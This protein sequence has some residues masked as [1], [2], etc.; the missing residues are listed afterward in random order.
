MPKVLGLPEVKV[1]RSKFPRPFK[2]HTTFNNGEIIPIMYDCNITPGDVVEMPLSAII[3]T[4]TPLYPV[5]DN[6]Y[7]DV[8]VWFVPDR[9]TWKHFK[10][11][12]GEN[13]ETFWEEETQYEIPQIEAPENGW[14]IGSLADY[15]GIPTNVGGISVS[16]M[17]FR[18]YCMIW[19]E[20]W[21]D[22]NL[23]EPIFFNDDETTLTGINYN[24]STFDYTTDIQLGA[25]PM[26]AAR[27]ADYYSKALP[28]PQ[29][30]EDVNIPLGTT[31]PVIGTG[32]QLGLQGR[33]NG[34]GTLYSAIGLVSTGNNDPNRL[35][36]TFN[37]KGANDL[38]PNDSTN[39]PVTYANVT[40]G[41][42]VTQVKEDSGLI[43]DLSEALSAT[44]NQ[45][46]T[47][48]ALQR[49]YEALARSGSRYI[50]VLAGIFGVESSDKTLQRPQ[51][52][53]GK[54]VPMN[55][56]QIVATAE[57]NNNDLGETGAMSQ[58][59]INDYLGTFSFE[60]HGTLMVLAVARHEHTYSQG[61]PRMLLRK[62]QFDFY[63]RA[64]DHLGEDIVYNAEIFAQGTD[65]D[66]EVFGYQPRYE[67]MRLGRSYVS[68]E[69]RNDATGTLNSWTYQD[70]YDTLP[71]LSSEWIDEGVDEVDRTLKVT[72]KSA[73]QIFGDFYFKCNYIRGMSMYGTPG[74][75][76]HM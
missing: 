7:L 35:A 44:V 20:F 18:A 32:E 4:Q 14:A 74:F 76:D 48:I 58:T 68:G 24:S 47:A 62:K 70:D 33:L 55:M 43:A 71:T 30:G 13:D 39:Y 1:G 9:L 16:H 41:L 28:E 52:L 10:N 64:L 19:N 29:K 25:K 12:W 3:R 54:R 53:A 21:R 42:G 75:M 8:S 37:G 40:A 36:V 38:G 63:N 67:D 23:K 50:E 17:P 15:F 60:E 26:V 2:H 51:F 69:F 73:N 56:T 61:I 65:E 22:E 66:M 27:V 34:T 6:M 49:Y 11:F 72:S 59:I 57:G 31:A 45:L 46:R 5:M